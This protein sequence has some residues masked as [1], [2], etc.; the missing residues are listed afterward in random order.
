MKEKRKNKTTNHTPA[1][2]CSCY[3][4]ITSSLCQHYPANNIQKDGLV[5]KKEIEEKTNEN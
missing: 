5:Q 4:N 3:C 1:A 2:N